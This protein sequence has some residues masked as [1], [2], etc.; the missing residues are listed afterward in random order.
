MVDQITQNSVFSKAAEAHMLKA[1]NGYIKQALHSP[2]SSL[3]AIRGVWKPLTK[4][5]EPLLELFKEA[6]TGNLDKTA[7]FDKDPF[8]SI[9]DEMAGSSHEVVP[10]LNQEF[11]YILASVINAGMICSGNIGQVE[12]LKCHISH[13]Y[14]STKFRSNF[15][16]IDFD[17]LQ[18]DVKNRFYYLGNIIVI[19][20]IFISVLEF[21]LHEIGNSGGGNVFIRDEDWGKRK[22]VEFEGTVSS[23]TEVIERVFDNVTDDGVDLIFC[24]KA[25]QLFNGD[26]AVTLNNKGHIIF[27]LTIPRVSD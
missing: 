17:L 25:M 22:I 13:N 5:R 19:D 8:Q 18:F 2:P 6:L 3:Y 23:S 1:V 27:T 10:E 20:L 7:L 9:R 4:E 21:L 24:K 15:K 16:D 11:D 14:S 12:L 26:I